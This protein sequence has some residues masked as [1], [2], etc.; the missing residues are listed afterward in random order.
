MRSVSRYWGEAL[1]RVAMQV[2][3]VRRSGSVVNIFPCW[4]CWAEAPPPAPPSERRKF[5]TASFASVGR[6]EE[7]L[8]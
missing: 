2:S 3:G 7:A 5:C 6:P 4:G 1:V 8:V